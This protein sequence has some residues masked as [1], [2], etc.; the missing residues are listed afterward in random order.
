MESAA[1]R[2]AVP[3]VNS[4]GVDSLMSYKKMLDIFFGSTLLQP[5]WFVPQIHGQGF[6]KK[7]MK[8]VVL[9]G[10]SGIFSLWGRMPN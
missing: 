8:N 1:C 7:T 5:D 9:Y 2:I 4:I 6:I 3:S 10:F